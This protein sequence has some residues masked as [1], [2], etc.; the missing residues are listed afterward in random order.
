MPVI[1]HGMPILDLSGEKIGEVGDFAVDSADGMPVRLSARTGLLSKHEREL[2]IG[3]I[4]EL[5]RDG[6]VLN[7]ARHEMDT[8]QDVA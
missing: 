3:W 7:L 1:R 8:H 2:P 6:V 5:A 4:K